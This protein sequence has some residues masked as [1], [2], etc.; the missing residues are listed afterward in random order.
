MKPLYEMA[1]EFKELLSLAEAAESPEEVEAFADTLQGLKGAI[2][3]K[4]VGCAMVLRTL[5]AQETAVETEEK[6]LKARRQTLSNAQD[7]LK[8]YMQEGMEA[9]QIDKIKSELF[10]IAIQNNPAKV[11][12]EDES[13]IP[14]SFW[15]VE[16]TPRVSD[17]AAAL[18][19]KIEVPGACLIQTRGLRIR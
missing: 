2:E 14:E 12:I 19:D 9:A 15:K 11:A 6:R 4:T 7:R 8:K 18:K 17:I 13:K 1:S 5:A 10:T 3:Q 16:R